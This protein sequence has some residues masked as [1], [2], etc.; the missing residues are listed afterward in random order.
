MAPRPT[1]GIV[2]NLLPGQLCSLLLLLHLVS[3]RRVLALTFEN[4]L[5]FG[6]SF[7]SVLNVEA[8]SRWLDFFKLF[9]RRMLKLNLTDQ[10]V[11]RV[12]AVAQGDR[13][14]DQM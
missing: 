4:N 11:L 2:Q 12:T 3:E 1:A 10:E 6:L 13:D 8:R 14:Q 9:L 5:F 7:R